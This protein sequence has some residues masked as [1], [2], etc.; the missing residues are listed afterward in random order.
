MFSVPLIA[1]PAPTLIHVAIVDDDEAICRAMVRLLRAAG[2]SVVAFPSAESFLAD[3]GGAQIDCLLL[4]IQLGGMSGIELQ[5]ELVAAGPTPPIV[6]LSAHDDLAMRERAML[7]GCVAFLHKTQPADRLLAAIRS[8]AE[9]LPEHGSEVGLAPLPSASVGVRRLVAVVD[10]QPPVRLVVARF[11]TA[12]GFD[13]LPAG[14]SAELFRHELSGIDCFV[15]DIVLGDESGLELVTRLRQAGLVAPIVIISGDISA[16]EWAR[17]V[18]G[19]TAY[20][21]KPFSANQ[22]FQAVSQALVG[23]A[24]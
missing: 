1:M 2:M 7:N 23:I 5:A 18:G 4:D 6:F 13:C 21:A 10:D 11:L 19:A 20:L 22:L 8:A 9:G 3:R 12:F 15:V 16:L 24:A 17:S 14:S